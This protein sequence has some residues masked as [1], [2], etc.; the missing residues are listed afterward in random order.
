MFYYSLY[1]HY[2]N[3]LHSRLCSMCVA[4]YYYYKK[5]NIINSPALISMEN[6]NHGST[7]INESI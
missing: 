3:R 6:A 4:N 5:K 1:F 7:I 2:S